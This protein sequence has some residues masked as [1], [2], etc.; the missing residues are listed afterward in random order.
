MLPIIKEDYTPGGSYLCHLF[1][2]HSTIMISDCTCKNVFIYNHN[3]YRWCYM[4]MFLCLLLVAICT[5]C[6]WLGIYDYCC[7]FICILCNYRCI[8]VTVH[9]L[10]ISLHPPYNIAEFTFCLKVGCLSDN[11]V[12]DCVSV[13]D[14]LLCLFVKDVLHIIDLL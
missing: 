7:A 5:L 6:H 8:Y 14:L 4:D 2:M 3:V 1:Y 13:N 11:S 9:V 10:R 12:L